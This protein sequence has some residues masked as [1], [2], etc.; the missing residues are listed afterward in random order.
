MPNRSRW[1]RFALVACFGALLCLPG[2]GRPALWEPDEGR[3]AEIAREMLLRGDYLTPHDDWVRYFEKPP[4]MYWLT[5]A[6]V[7]AFGP[8]EFAV[9]LPVALF[10]V[11]EIILAA[12]VSGAMF[13]VETIVPAALCLGLSP[14]F[15]GYGRFLTLDPALAFFITAGLAA[16]YVGLREATLAGGQPRAWFVAA[17][18]SAAMGTLV[19]GPVALVLIAGVALVYMA[20]D[21]QTKRLWQIP[22]VWCTATY[23]LIAL[24]WFAMVERRNPDFARFFIVHEHIERYLRSTEHSWG[25][26]FLPAVAI[27]GAWPWV[28]FVPFAL[29]GYRSDS[30]PSR[31]SAVK[32]L[33]TWVCCVVIFFSAARSKLGSYVLPAIPPMAV[34]AGYGMVRA[35]EWASGASRSLTVPAVALNTIVGLIAVVAAV[36]LTLCAAGVPQVLQWLTE[37]RMLGARVAGFCANPAAARLGSEVAASVAV[38]SACGALSVAFSRGRWRRADL[39]VA[40]VG[41]FAA[42]ALLIKARNDAS[43]LGSYRRLAQ[44]IHAPLE[45]GCVLASYRHFV[46]SLPFYTGAREALVSYRGE[47]EPFSRSL[48]ARAS[49]INNDADLLALWRSSQCVILIADRQYLPDL[50]KFLSPAPQAVASEGQKVALSNQVAPRLGMPP[51]GATRELLPRD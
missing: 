33:V 40:A 31:R 15:F 39:A 13:G 34:L 16:V 46:Q 19:K 2:L 41:G 32:F 50:A 43:P 26:W 37:W 17:A 29:K 14:L 5:A 47:L 51:A 44:A 10:S 36:L 28:C 49:F 1:R 21:G 42:M 4:L 45:Q 38:L 35:R 22:W 48:D 27:G 18:A 24:P 20:L 6:S 30:D 7:R 11:G 25:A 3:Y 8:G 23:A 12:A 9:R